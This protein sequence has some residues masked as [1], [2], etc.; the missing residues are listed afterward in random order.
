MTEEDGVK[1]ALVK[2]LGEKIIKEIVKD[3]KKEDVEVRTGLDSKG[4]FRI[5]PSNNDTYIVKY[6]ISKLAEKRLAYGL[7]KGIEEP[8]KW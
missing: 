5:E 6:L 1:T 4:I 8:E 7:V 2:A 3:L